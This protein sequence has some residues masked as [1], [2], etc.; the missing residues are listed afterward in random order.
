MP[1]RCDWVPRN[2]DLYAAYHDAEWGVPLRDRRMLFELLCLEGAQAGLSWRTIL[3][4]REGYR[5]AFGGFD[6]EALAA[7][8]EDDVRR[9]LEDASIVRSAPKIRSVISNA[10]ALLALEAS[11]IGWSD[12]IWSFVG[13]QPIIGRWSTSREAPTTSTAGTEL[14]RDLKR[15]GFKF[16]G[17]TICYSFMQ[18]AGLVMDHEVGCF[19]HSELSSG[20]P[21]AQPSPVST[22][23]LR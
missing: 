6:P 10:R 17:P 7:F 11:G 21:P 8:G 12:Y 16:V 15:R 5:L 2:D 4:R 18:A 22:V 20:G 9:L 13:G 23:R 14:S 1:K 19:R 3:Y